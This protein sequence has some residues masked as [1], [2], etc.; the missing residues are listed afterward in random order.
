MP[1]VAF[2]QIYSF[3]RDTL[4]KAIPRPEKMA[5]KE[6]ASAAAELLDRILQ[7]ADNAGATDEHR[8]LNY[9]AVRYPGFYATAADAFGRNFSLTAIETHP[10]RLSGVRRIVDVVS[11]YRNRQTDVEEKYFCRVDITEEFAFLVTKMAP[12]FDR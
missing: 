3:D 12:F 9:C 7:I 6:F 4:L 2:D 1:V 8:A 11:S 5:A 10:S